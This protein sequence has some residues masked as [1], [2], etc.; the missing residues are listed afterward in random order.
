MDN[1]VKDIVDYVLKSCKGKE[2]EVSENFITFLISSTTYCSGNPISKEEKYKNQKITEMI[3]KKVVNISSPSLVTLKMQQYFLESYQNRE[4]IIKKH[5]SCLA[6]K[7]LPLIKEICDFAVL[8]NTTALEQLYQKI[9]VVI[10]ILSGLGDPTISIILREVGL[11]LHS[12]FQPSELARF[13]TLSEFE[14]E[15]QLTELMHIVSGIRLFNRDGQRGG[16][17]ID[18]LP[19]I[20]QNSVN[21]SRTIIVHL[22]ESL[23][24]KIYNLTAIVEAGIKSDDVNDGE[25]QIDNNHFT[26]AL[27]ALVTAR[28]QEVYVRKLLMDL[29]ICEKEVELLIKELKNK[30]IK[31][32]EIVKYRTAIPTTQVY[33]QFIEIAKTWFK[34][35]DEVLV[36][37][38]LNEMLCQLRSFLPQTLESRYQTVIELLLDEIHVLTDSER[39][40]RTM[41]K[42]IEDSG[43]C[44]IIY[45][46]TDH[47]FNKVNLQFLGFCT[48]SF[49]VGNG[50][51]IPGNPNIGILEWK[52]KYFAFS[53][54]S[55]AKQFS[56]Q[57]ALD[58]VERNLE[59]IHFFQLFDQI[60]IFNQQDK[61][62]RGIKPPKLFRNQEIQTD[63]HILP[64]FIDTNY[65]SNIWEHRRKAIKLAN[66]LQS[67][68]KSTQTVKSSFRNGMCIQTMSKNEKETQTRVDK[69]INTI[70]VNKLE[71]S[72]MHREKD[73]NLIDFKL[74]SK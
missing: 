69:G 5:R 39:L 28:Q 43:K 59:F 24:D 26:W 16:E 6:Q 15:S 45:P 32:H 64:T 29:D 20:L 57:A 56:K 10:T 73:I 27:K 49:V 50:A 60:N 7:T 37:S 47:T 72:L 54:V 44:A 31:L 55:A 48:W 62:S 4:D 36:I 67:A 14:K 35:Q 25:S 53:S 34:L 51:I 66:M 9:L 23:M 68:C 46:N 58:L 65:S 42:L 13:V 1:S 41:G 19:S 33:P 12:V 30:F 38:F 40:E 52:E 2:V 63:L 8:D 22:L 70:L 74:L 21:T 17:G 18:D 61:F 3:I 11:A 71:L